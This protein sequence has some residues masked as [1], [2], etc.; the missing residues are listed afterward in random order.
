M[1]NHGTADASQGVRP[2]FV[3]AY[4]Q[5]ETPEEVS[6]RTF[7]ANATMTI[8]GIIGIVLAV[9]IVG[10]LLPSGSSG[11]G[12]WSALTKTELDALTLATSKP[13]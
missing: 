1:S 12:S 9:P 3:S 4:D 6:R 7:M 2:K 8:S 5:P 10:S 11:K 13:V